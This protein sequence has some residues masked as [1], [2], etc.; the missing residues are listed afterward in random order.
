M[1]MFIVMHEWQLK[2]KIFIFFA[3]QLLAKMHSRVIIINYLLKCNPTP[4]NL[5]EDC[6]H[7]SQLTSILCRQLH[8]LTA[9]RFRLK[10]STIESHMN[11]PQQKK[12][13]TQTPLFQLK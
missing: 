10:T 1:N 9:I 4:N 8:S 2:F 12:S 11:C 3:R 5:R 6:I 13:S 7:N